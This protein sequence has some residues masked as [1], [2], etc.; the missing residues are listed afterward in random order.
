MN[1]KNYAPLI[2][3]LIAVFNISSA[4]AQGTYAGNLTLVD[5]SAVDAFNYSEVTGSLTL[6]GDIGNLDPLSTLTTLGGSLSVST[7]N[8]A[9]YTDAFPNLTS[10]GGGI[11]FYYTG[12]NNLSGFDAL[13]STGDNIDFWYNDNL[14]SVTGFSALQTVGWSLEFGENPVLTQIPEFASLVT[15]SSSLFILDNVSLASIQGLDSLQDVAWSFQVQGNT[16]LVDACG[17][18]TYC[19][20]NPTYGGGGSLLI[21]ANALPY[22]PYTIDDMATEGACASQ[23]AEQVEELISDVE[24]MELS[25]GLE[26]QL[27]N[28]MKHTLDIIEKNDVGL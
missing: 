9:N 18:Y 11:Y 23:M 3:I 28:S 21:S 4:T 22:D 15:I 1:S 20:F 26:N 17:F 10:I 16:S 14:T 12:M 8:N 13:V 5:Q 25:N 7:T 24:E 19:T 2:V 6:S 27:I